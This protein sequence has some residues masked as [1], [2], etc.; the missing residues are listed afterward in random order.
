[1]ITRA[2]LKH[3]S[4][5]FQL[6][7]VILAAGCKHKLP[8]VDT[9]R[10]DIRLTEANSPKEVEDIVRASLL[11][12]YSSTN[13]AEGYSIYQVTNAQARWVFAKVYNAPR[14][15]S[16]FN[17]YCHEQEGPESWRLRA[18]VPLNAHYYTNSD[19]WGLT[20]QTDH[21][22]VNALFRGRV[23]FTGISRMGLTNGSS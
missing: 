18:Y 11:E 1:M 4:L 8:P 14:G 6:L 19:D 22:Y 7:L 21:N 17:L 16:M 20:F 5:P 15:L 12:K 13:I 10:L 23:I 2:A 3:F 9:S